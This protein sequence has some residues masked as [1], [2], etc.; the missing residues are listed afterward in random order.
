[1]PAPGKSLRRTPFKKVHDAKS[2][3][4]HILLAL[5]PLAGCRPVPSALCDS[6][7]Q[8][9]RVVSTAPAL[10]ELLCA[11]GAADCLAGRT[12]AC[13]YPPEVAARTPVTGKF[14]MPNVEQVLALRASHLLESELVNPAQARILQ[15]R[16]VRIEH[17]ECARVADIPAAART[18]GRLT[19]RTEAAENLASRLESGLA[20]LAQEQRDERPRTLILLDHLTPVTCGTNTFISEMAAL[21]GA[22]NL[23]TELQKEYATVSLE[24]IIE[25]KP[26]LILCFYEIQGS[27]Q[28]HFAGRTGWKDLPAVR[29]GRIAVPRNL[30]LICRPGPRLL[31]GID[32]LRRCIEKALGE[33]GGTE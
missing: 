16:G 10:T 20:R 30:D 28:E 13:D 31:Q 24:W 18:I 5:L 6:T 33:S 7:P 22:N 8:R 23:A 21:A 15:R 26:E 2:I 9:A 32:E 25:Q 11:V 14:G 19:G 3:W 4:A 27:P 17:I 1:M 12:D 29:S